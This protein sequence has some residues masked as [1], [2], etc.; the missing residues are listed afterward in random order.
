MRSLLGITMNH[1]VNTL[2]LFMSLGCTASS[3][4]DPGMV[5]GFDNIDP[6]AN[7]AWTPCFD[8]FT[9]SKLEVPLDYSKRSL[10][11]TSIAFI[12]LAGKNATA[13]SPSL[14]LIPGGP[15]G[16]GVD[17][18]LTY[19]TLTGQ[20]FGEQY[21]IV[22]FDPR[23]VN[24]SGLR[25]DCF[26]GN[27]E[28]RLAFSRLHSTGVTNISST[29]LEDQYYSS[30][31]YGEWCNHAVENESPNGYY[32]TTPAVAHDL[33]TFIESE[34]KV[35]GQSPSDA[36][37]W[38][39]GISY[40]TVIGSTFASMFPNR[41][42]RMILDGVLNAEQYYNNDWRDNVD[43]MDEAMEKFSAFCHSAGPEKCSFWGPTPAK[44]T[45]RM[46]SIIHQLQTHPVP[47]NG[48]QSQDLPT[49]VTYSDLKALFLNTISAPLAEFPAMANILHQFELGDVSALS[50]MFYG[51]NST[52][53]ARLAIQCADSYRRNRL[54]TI[55]EFKSYVEYTISKS[56]YIG[57]IYPIYLE[58]I[59]CR[60]FR[61]QLPDSMV[62]QGPIRG[63]D[64]PTSFPILFASNTIDPI[65]PLESARKMSSR[66][67]GSII[68]LQDAIGTEFHHPKKGTLSGDSVTLLIIKF[69]ILQL[70]RRKKKTSTGI[71]PS[72]DYQTTLKKPLSDIENLISTSFLTLLSNPMALVRKDVLHPDPFQHMRSRNHGLCIPVPRVF[73]WN[74]DPSNP[75]GSEYIIMEKAKGTALGDVW[76]RLPNPSKH[77]FIKHLVELEAKLAA[78]PFPG[79]G[80]IYYKQDLQTPYPKYQISF[81]EDESVKFCIGPVVDPVF[82]SDGRAEMTLDRGPCINER[83]W[84]MRSARPRINYYRSNTD[85]E[86]P[87]EYI[88]LIEKYLLVVPHLTQCE[89]GS[90]ELL[91]PKLWH[92]D[93]TS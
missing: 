34:A 69:E 49:L 87:S 48:V 38:C 4:H 67:A 36:K 71:P 68:L 80:C 25:L 26:S 60:S 17:L 16:S 51:L 64:K 61:P 50:G 24:N 27:I 55:E 78:M 11:T 14:V 66:F 41:V 56:K 79:H 65:T 89:P 21:N 52:S 29:S 63:L 31:I 35:A 75:V 22:S 23:G 42:G 91:K 74:C 44:I 54:T 53:D 57:D 45:A 37:L 20:I 76:Y 47:V 12:K 1:L 10:G 39:Y 6:S 40:G 18:L 5:Y 86:M 15:G 83:I 43:Q 84:A 81:G 77:K 7:L 90:S 46:D 73:T 88:D 30:S 92:T 3:S 82:W 2:I 72:D 93:L 33:L 62:I 28:A 70:S 13:E 32:V 9:C 8:N 58:T 59:L 85:H 19:R